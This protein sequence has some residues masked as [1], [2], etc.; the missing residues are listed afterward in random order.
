MRQDYSTKYHRDH[1][2]TVVQNY[3]LNNNNIDNNRYLF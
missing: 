3:C 1:R 2:G